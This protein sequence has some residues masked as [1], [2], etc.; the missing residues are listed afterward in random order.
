MKSSGSLCYKT[1]YA[2]MENLTFSSGCESCTNVTAIMFTFRV[3][4]FL[5]QTLRR[6]AGKGQ[7]WW[8]IFN[9]KCMLEIEL[10]KYHYFPSIF[11]FLQLR[12]ALEWVFPKG[13]DYVQYWAGLPQVSW[14]LLRAITTSVQFMTVEHFYSLLSCCNSN[15]VQ[16]F[17]RI[18]DFLLTISV[19]FWDS[20]WS[21]RWQSKELCFGYNIRMAF[22]YHLINKFQY[23]QKKQFQIN[24]YR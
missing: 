7:T 6:Y 1:E 15:N 9:I 17:E 16:S 13:R 19:P 2:A 5:D 24:I 12:P 21:D 23:D 11:E 3:T 22:Y 10:Q 8:Q 4:I 14:V 20:R 18:K